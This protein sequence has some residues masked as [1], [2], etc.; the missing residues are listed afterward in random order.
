M[1]QIVFVREFLKAVP[2]CTKKRIKWI[3]RKRNDLLKGGLLS[4]Q[5][6][7]IEND[8]KDFWRFN[9]LGW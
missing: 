3:Q 1:N 4:V 7:K 5:F 8:Y 9:A 2:S 6:Q